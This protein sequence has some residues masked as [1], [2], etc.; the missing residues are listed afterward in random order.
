MRHG[1]SEPC[2][3]IA[4]GREGVVV[5][6]ATNRPDRLDSALLRPGRFDRLQYV[7]LPDEAARLKILEVLTRKTPLQLGTDL[8]AIA[9]CT[10]G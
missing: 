3:C 2:Y 10:Q 8:S 7:G 6:G 9:A 1:A 4:Q 5:I